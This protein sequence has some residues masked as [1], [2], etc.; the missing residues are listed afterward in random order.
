MAV[1]PIFSKNGFVRL[2]RGVQNLEVVHRLL[3][4]GM[5]VLNEADSDLGAVNLGQ[6]RKLSNEAT[7]DQNYGVFGAR[8]VGTA[9][10]YLPIA[11]FV[12][13]GT[14]SYDGPALSV[15][16]IVSRNTVGAPPI[17]TYDL[18]I[19]DVTNGNAI[20]EVTGVTALGP[21]L[22]NAAPA[23]LPTAEATFEIQMKHDGISGGLFVVPVATCWSAR[24]NF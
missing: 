17:T 1:N 18:R 22:I 9:P 3:T 6:A 10:A 19:F 13:K 4:Q 15:D 2:S 14:V 21:V 24:F 12:W 8:A 7:L 23:N 5:T 20:A 11:Q 16:A